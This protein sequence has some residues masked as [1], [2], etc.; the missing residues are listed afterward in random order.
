MNALFRATNQDQ[1]FV[2]KQTV[3]KRT[4]KST[5]PVRKPFWRRILRGFFLIAVIL[6]PF[7]LVLVPLYTVVPPVSTLMIKDLVTLK[8]YKRDWVP[9]ED[10][11]TVAVHSIMV[12]EDARHCVHGGV[13]WVEMRKAWSSIQK[14]G[15]GRGA[16]TMTMQVAKN[17]FLW[18]SRSYV[19]KALELPLAL[20]I[21]LIWSKRRTMEV[22]LNIAEWGDSIYGIEAASQH[23]FN[24]PAKKL[25]RTQSALLAVSL[26]NPIKRSAGMPSRGLRRLAN[27]IISRARAAGPY[28]GCLKAN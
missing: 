17:L 11:S 4:R 13:D 2:S 12:S 3:K 22:Y 18:N 7:P 24:K 26:P 28:V 8:G 5:T 10:I 21:D 1:H 9:L 15:R 27:K 16:S 14:G 19:R 20:Y 23:H 6:V 25:N